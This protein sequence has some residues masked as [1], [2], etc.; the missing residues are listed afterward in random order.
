MRVGRLSRRGLGAASLVVSLACACG[1]HAV[2]GG[3]TERFRVVLVR[4]LVPDAI[5]SDE[6]VSGVR[7]AL[8]REG[9][10][11]AGEGYPRVEVEVLRAD[12]A[13]EGIAAPSAALGGSVSGTG[14]GSSGAQG[15][16][17]RATEVGL[18]ARAC[19]VRT[20]GGTC[21]R[22]TGDMRAMDLA[23]SDLTAGAPDLA[24]DAFHH[25]DV[26]RDVGKRLGARLADH[27]LGNPAASDEAIGRE[28]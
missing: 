23:A 1:Y 20:K 27:I 26:L 18:V 10:L 13:S 3:D 19:L 22:D 7:E 9:A 15:P 14:A 11:A 16:R 21:E 12:E 4:S 28:R 17:A 5:A 2:Y 8:A 24:A 25:R 6:V